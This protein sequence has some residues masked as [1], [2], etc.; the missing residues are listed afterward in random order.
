[1]Q[2]FYDLLKCKWVLKIPCHSFA[3]VFLAV[4]VLTCLVSVNTAFAQSKG[5]ITITGTVTDSVGVTIIG[6]N[7]SP[8][9]TKGNSTVTDV[10]GKFVLDVE[11]GA[12]Y[13][14]TYVG[15]VEKQFTASADN[16]IIR[17]SLSAAK[18]QFDD[19]VVTAYNR[20]QSRE[21][22]VGSVTTV[23]PGNL[24]IPASN[25]TNALAGQ[26]AGVIAYQ[27][28]GQPGL[29]NSNFFIRGVTTFGYKQNPLILIDNVELSASDLARLNVDDI[30]SFSILK[31]ASS[32][33]L[34]GAR[35]G[36]GVILVKTKEGKA[37]KPVINARLENSSSQSVKTLAVADP[38]TYMKLFN[39]ATSTRFPLDPLPYSQN[40][41]LSTQA[42]LANQPGSNKYVYPAVDWLDMLFKKRT[43]TQRADLSLSGGSGVARYYVAGSYDNDNGILKTDIQNN[44]NNNVKFQNYQLRSNVNINVT[45]KTELVV[46][47]WGNFNEYNGPQTADGNFSTDMYNY[48]L[49]TSPVDFPAFYPADAQ[50]LNTKHIL[51]GNK[52]TTA[53]NLA[54]INPYAQLLSG[55]KN[56]TESRMQ[57]QLELNQNFDFFIPGLNFHSIFA[58]N[59]YSSFQSGQAYKPYYYAANNYDAQTDQYTLLWLNSLPGQA[60]E[61]LSYVPGASSLSTQLYLQANLDYAH[62]FGQD[63]SVSSA[64]IFTRDQTRY[65]NVGTLFAA[66]PFRNQTIA[67]R[68]SY[69]YKGRYHLEANFGYNGSERFSENHRYGFFPTIGASWIISD[70]KFWGNLYNVFDRFKLRASYGLVG[71]DAISDQ[72]FYY[73]SDV[74]LGGATDGHTGASFGTNLYHLPGVLINNYENRDVTWETSKQLNLGLELTMMKKINLTLEVYRNNKYNILQGLNN[75]N[76]P[77]TMGLESS[78]AANVGKVRS[79]GIDF[80][81]DGN[82]RIGK[83]FSL[84]L[85]GNFTLSEN[86]F[87][88]YAEPGYKEG[89]RSIIGQTLWRTSGL[90]A[91]RLFVDD[92]EAANSP[93]QI[94]SANGPAPKGGDIKY[95]DLNNDGKID[96]ADVTY[97]GYPTIPQ[98]VY[99]FGFTSAYKNFDF[100]GFF[101]GQA[102][103]SFSIDPSKTSPFIKS[104]EGQFTGNTQL[105]QAYADDHW[106]EDNQNLYA[107]YPRLGTNGDDITNNRQ[108]STWWLRDGSFLRLKSVEVGFTLPKQISHSLRIRS[109]RI[110]FNGLNLL[111]WSPF[112]LWDPEQGG[113]AFAYPVQK[114]FNVGL[115]VN[116]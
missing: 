64:L 96:G 8:V 106:S 5:K 4:F 60:Q 29:D 73:L 100:S 65:G 101:Q 21:A 27:P 109:A 116:L 102:R 12:L 91:E 10:N 84:G 43:S 112:K 87:V 3:G 97:F 19:V 9:N 95:R 17:I 35:G 26:V 39:E 58:T 104:S 11:V 107:L 77:S 57:A 52:S 47:L 50:N 108:V 31:D 80:S 48:A 14:V 44:N 94:F 92:N 86:K 81:L 46:R 93:T 83:D 32:T 111:T 82:Q 59:R 70:E 33:A 2:K 66:L 54:F 99:G 15:F 114:V 13:K 67:G 69:A 41:I 72:R 18:S 90:I 20:K 56:Y 28:G 115:N 22:V 62:T 36:N 6:A 51:F 88:E 61:Y 74:N 53:G 1:M 23:K 16:K 76:I 75:T 37:G 34:Y 45:S 55:H 63:H 79:Q 85:R 110:Y 105:L 38:I 24:R 68:V 42:A 71:N 49:H 78:I 7:I 89:Y 103:V 30:E 113:N 25:L 98:I 40:K